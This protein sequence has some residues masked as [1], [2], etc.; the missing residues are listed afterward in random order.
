MF[1]HISTKSTNTYN[2]KHPAT[3]GGSPGHAAIIEHSSINVYLSAAHN[4]N[5]ASENHHHFT[6]DSLP[7][8]VLNGIKREQAK[9]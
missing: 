8:M 6:I 4:L 7:Q 2:W 5:I 9:N 1:L 3:I